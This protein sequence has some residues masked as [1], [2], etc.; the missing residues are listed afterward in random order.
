MVSYWK[1]MIMCSAFLVFVCSFCPE[2]LLTPAFP[3]LPFNFL[4]LTL[5]PLLLP[6][7][8]KWVSEFGGAREAL[9]V[10]TAMPAP[11]QCGPC[12]ESLSLSNC[13]A[14]HPGLWYWYVWLY[15]GTL[16]VYFVCILMWC[17]FCMMYYNQLCMCMYVYMVSSRIFL[18][19]GEECS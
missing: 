12:H 14:L 13:H 10:H 8:R 15:F 5:P 16:S 7:N 17:I 6:L 18:F 2:C 9:V 11:I 19:G 1:K 3:C 4:P